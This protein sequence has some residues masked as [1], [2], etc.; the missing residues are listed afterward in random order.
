MTDGFVT[1]ASVLVYFL[2]LRSLDNTMMNPKKAATILIL[3]SLGLAAVV[4][5]LK[6][7][8]LGTP[9]LMDVITLHR[10]MSGVVQFFVAG[11]IFYK[12]EHTGDEYLSF[13]FWGGLG[14]ALIFFVV[15]VVMRSLLIAL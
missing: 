12:V 9:A 5:M 4:Q 2:L 7:L 6:N 1:I 10:C 14:M 8:M 15:P 3:C 11:Y 13:A